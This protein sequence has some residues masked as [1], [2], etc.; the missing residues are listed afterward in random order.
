MSEATRSTLARYGAVLLAVGLML[1][2]RLGLDPVLGHG[3]HLLPFVLAVVLAAWQGGLWLGVAATLLSVLAAAFFVMEPTG[4]LLMVGEEDRASVILFAIVALAV[5]GF[6]E[7]LH[8]TRRRAEASARALRQE[9]EER[10]ALEQALRESEERFRTMADTAPVLLWVAGADGRATFFNRPWQEFTG[11]TLDEGMRE[12]WAAVHPDDLENT[13]ESYQ[14]AFDARRSSRLEYRLRRADGVYRWMLDCAVPRFMPDGTFAGYI[15]SC[16]DITEHKQLEEAL[17]QRAEALTEAD[18]QKDAFLAML[19]HELRNPIAPIRNAA[20]I[21]RLR[22]AENPALRRAAEI[23][24]RQAQH[25]ARM[26]DDLLDVSRITWGRIEL[27]PEPVSLDALLRQAG[28]NVRPLV[29]EREQTLSLSL[30]S[31]ILWLEAD[32]TRLVQVVTNLLHNAAKYTDPG[33]RIELS[34]RRE[35]SDA[36]IRIRDT[37]AGIAPELLPHVFDPFRQADRTLDRAQG[38]LGIGL[39]LVQR[40]VQLHGGTVTAH[41]EGPGRGSE[42]VLRLPAIPGPPPERDGKKEPPESMAAGKRVLVVDDNRDAAS[43]LA[44]LLELQG[45]EVCVAFDGSEALVMA[46]QQ[47]PQVVLLDIGL[48]GIDGYEVARR[49]RDVP[50]LRDAVLVALTGYGHE[51]DRR[52]SREA[53]FDRHLVKP[54]NVEDLDAALT[55][56]AS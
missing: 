24:E 7:A 47:R 13:R 23:V 45:H 41:S 10:S 48:P 4:S 28:D 44:D 53:G 42:F 52:R 54:V 33:G 38:G 19:S 51:E 35:G 25:L 37:G 50:G 27:Q 43:S 15:G 26:V 34:A 40:L 8:M 49:M 3:A 6:A 56:A 11:Q 20:H 12:C 2:V 5:S 17:R 9:I 31:E 46:R 36:V 16:V 18:R 32:P 39:T 21:L 30:P 55:R 29:E 14:A 22:T 1:L